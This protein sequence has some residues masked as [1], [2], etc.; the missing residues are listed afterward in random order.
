MFASN[1]LQKK[2]TDEFEG[3]EFYDPFQEL[4]HLSQLKTDYDLN[5]STIIPFDQVKYI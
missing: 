3:Q 5:S 2:Q 4:D 1:L